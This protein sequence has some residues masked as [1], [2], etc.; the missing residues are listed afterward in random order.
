MKTYC[1]PNKKVER[2]TMDQD[3]PTM[4]ESLLADFGV[5]TDLSTPFIYDEKSFNAMLARERKRTERSKRQFI[6]VTLSRSEIPAGENGKNPYHR[7]LSTL[8]SSIRDIDVLG[9]YKTGL[10]LGIIFPEIDDT[11]KGMATSSILGRVKTNL[12]ANLTREERE[13]LEVSVYLFPETAGPA[14]SISDLALYPDIQEVR[15]AKRIPLMVKRAIDLI[16]SLAALIVF[17]P[18]FLVISVLIRLTSEGPVFFRQR[19]VGQYGKPFTFMKFRSMYINNDPA[20]H[21]DYVQNMI[22]SSGSPDRKN[23]N[24]QEKVFKIQNDPRVTTFG[25]FLR[26][27]SL[28]ELPQFIN[29]LKGEMSLVGPRPPIPYECENYEVWHR[30]RIL[31]MKPGIT[32]LWQVAGRSRTSFDEMVRLDIYY[33]TNWSLWLDLKLLLQTPRAVLSRKG[34]F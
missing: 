6:L 24:C 5:D 28:D 25:R 3:F 18:L 34:A 1:G 23:G 33:L 4:Q 31:D 19:R 17:S 2:E 10:V 15:S 7:I 9:W 29:V 22:R 12:A 21:R 20:I 8:S 32:G 16:G 11:S 13:K 14:E 27:T 30:R 26:K